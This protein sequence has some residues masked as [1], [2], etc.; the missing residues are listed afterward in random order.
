MSDEAT[1]SVELTDEELR[2]LLEL[3]EYI[4]SVE[5]AAIRKKLLLEE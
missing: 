4:P 3:I 1:I 2:L 5:F